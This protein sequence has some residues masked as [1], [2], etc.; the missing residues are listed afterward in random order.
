MIEDIP[1]TVPAT[2]E[3]TDYNG[4]K[5][6]LQNNGSIETYLRNLIR[7][8]YT[9]KTNI[10]IDEDY[11]EEWTDPKDLEKRVPVFENINLCYNLE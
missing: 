9:N 6:V 7:Y 11:D 4:N 3:Y 8:Q 10:L 2:I 5:V 1:S